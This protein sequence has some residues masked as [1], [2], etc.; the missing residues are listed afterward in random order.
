MN[1]VFESEITIR[2]D[3]IDLNNHVHNAKFI[4]FIQAARYQQMKLNY[5]MP[6]DDFL[7]LGYNWV[8]STVHIEYKRPLLLDDRIV[9]RTQLDSINGAQCKVNFRIVKKENEKVASEGYFI[10]TM[11]SIKS[12][13]PVRISEDIIKKYSI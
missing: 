5:K 3:D 13:K 7:K 11:I 10:Y 8:A 1:S 9:V 6:M 4:D 2:P 12:G